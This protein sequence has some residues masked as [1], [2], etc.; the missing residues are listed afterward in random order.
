[1][2]SILYDER[3]TGS[4]AEIIPRYQPPETHFPPELSSTVRRGRAAMGIRSTSELRAK[5][6]FA[7]SLMCS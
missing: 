2:K 1:V 6:S 4:Q 5:L 7:T 3:F